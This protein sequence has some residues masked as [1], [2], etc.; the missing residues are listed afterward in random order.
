M[1]NDRPAPNSLHLTRSPG[2]FLVLAGLLFGCGGGGGGSSTTG[3]GVNEGSYSVDDFHHVNVHPAGYHPLGRD[4]IQAL[5]R[6]ELFLALPAANGV[7]RT[8]ELHEGPDRGHEEVQTARGLFGSD[9][10]VHGAAS[11][12]LDDDA[13]SELVVATIENAGQRLSLT[14]VN[15]EPNGTYRREP[16]WTTGAIGWAFAAARVTLGDVDGDRRDEVIVAARSRGLGEPA[17]NGQVW[18]IDDPEDGGAILMTFRRDAG[19]VDLAGLPIDTD[20]DGRDEVVVGLSGDTTAGGRYA[21]RLFALEERAATMREVH[22]W[23]YLILDTN[24]RDSRAVVG[25]FDGDGREDLGVVSYRLSSTTEMRVE[26]FSRAANDTWLSYAST[27]VIDVGPAPAFLPENWAACA[28]QPAVG[29][30]DIALAYPEGTTYDL[31][32]L[33]YLPNENRFD[34]RGG[35]IDRF[36]SG[37]GIALA[38]ADV[39]ADGTQELQV[40]LLRYTAASGALDLGTIADD[41]TLA[42]QDRRTLPGGTSGRP[43]VPLLAPGDFDADGFAL[44][45]TGRRSTRL[46]DPFPIAL[47]SAPPTVAGISQNIDDTESAYSTGVT[48]GTSIGVTS[49]TTMT[50]TASVGFDLFAGLG[51]QGRASIAHEMETTHTESRMET[52]VRGYRGAADA[53]VIVFQGTL[54][55]TYEYL[56]VGAPDPAAI[57]TL[58]TLDVPVDANV[59]NWTVDYYNA[60]VAPEDRIGADLLTH[61][62]GDAASYPTRTELLGELVGQLHWD[63]AGVHPVGQGSASDFQSVSFATESATEEQRTVTRGHGGGVSFGLPGFG[64]SLDVDRELAEGSTHGVTYASE[65]T[66]EASVGHIADPSDYERWRYNWGFSIQTVGRTADANNDPSGYDPNRKNSFQYLRYWVEPTGSGY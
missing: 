49:A 20:G 10:L 42:W 64:A 6:D 21:I 55:E 65:T 1:K 15:R 43:R 17:T 18:V 13:E 58:L 24:R 56:I 31:A 57:G 54:Y 32:R 28:F 66:F 39:D 26:L 46:S 60:N 37:Q 23:Q 5:S 51:A 40:G 47:L 3:G 4:G 27:S 8:Y 16:V 12:Q 25:D 63:L 34:H 2:A 61:T 59:Y 9:E 19:H 30:T 11:G 48:Q 22:G 14:L 52:V 33:H 36:A 53:D 41:G 44:Q 35:T 50:Y 62:P 29:R 38:A 7:G 45:S